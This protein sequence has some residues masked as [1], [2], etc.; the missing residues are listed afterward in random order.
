MRVSPSSLYSG[1]S[2][3]AVSSFASA[4]GVV[5]RNSNIALEWVTTT[6]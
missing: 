2:T 1:S 3:A 5:A 4:T 6:T